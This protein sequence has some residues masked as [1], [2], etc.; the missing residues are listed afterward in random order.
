VGTTKDNLP[1]GSN[2]NKI[3]YL[4]EQ[5][6]SLGGSSSLNVAASMPFRMFQDSLQPDSD[7]FYGFKYREYSGD[8]TVGDD[9]YF[10]FDSNDGETGLVLYEMQQK[11]LEQHVANGGEYPQLGSSDY[12]A[13]GIQL[14]LVFSAVFPSGYAP[15]DSQIRINLGDCYFYLP[16]GWDESTRTLTVDRSLGGVIKVLVYTPDGTPANLNESLSLYASP[17]L[18]MSVAGLPLSDADSVRAEGVIHVVS[19]SYVPLSG[20]LID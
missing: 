11:L 9:S 6:D 17:T 7:T 12:T 16:Y 8:L 14:S 4:A 2:R 20:A 10:Y 19:A 13:F 15:T 1:S 5:M 3:E 18:K